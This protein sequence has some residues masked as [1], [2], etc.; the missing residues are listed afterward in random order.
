M[1][2]DRRV[3]TVKNG[4]LEELLA[5]AEAELTRVR[6]QP[7]FAKVVRQYVDLI[8]R[9]NSY[10]IEFEWENLTDYERFWSVWP[11]TGE[12]AAFLAKLDELTEPGGTHEL[13]TVV[14]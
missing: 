3:F 13:W 11:T 5:L 12:A 10:V 1:F 8:A 7:D 14:G 2:V 9:F 4:R 6:Q